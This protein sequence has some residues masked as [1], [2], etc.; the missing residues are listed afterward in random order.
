VIVIS[1]G[2]TIDTLTG[3]ELSDDAITA[4]ALRQI[5]EVR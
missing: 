5:K 4:A 2:R 1:Q 3:D